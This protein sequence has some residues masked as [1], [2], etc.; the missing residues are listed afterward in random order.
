L[1]SSLA[2]ID[3]VGGADIMGGS[4]G[5][6]GTCSGRSSGVVLVTRA[7]EPRSALTWLVVMPENKLNQFYFWFWFCF[8]LQV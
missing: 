3:G 7:T 8:C 6:D 2:G 1:F 4:I 5:V